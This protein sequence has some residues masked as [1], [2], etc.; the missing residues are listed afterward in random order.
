MP[1]LSQ[2]RYTPPMT[3]TRT[4]R[5]LTVDV[6]TG[7]ALLMFGLFVLTNG[8]TVIALVLM[9]VGLVVLLTAFGR[10]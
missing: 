5:N 6:V 3:D 10:R 2:G 1:S 9:G 7:V 8:A 4:R